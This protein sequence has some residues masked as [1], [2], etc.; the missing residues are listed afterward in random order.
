MHFRQ[1]SDKPFM[2][3]WTISLF[4]CL[5][6]PKTSNYDYIQLIRQMLPQV[7]QNFSSETRKQFLKNTKINV[8][9][10][11]V[12][13]IVVIY[14]I[15]ISSMTHALTNIT[16]KQKLLYSQKYSITKA[17]CTQITLPISLNLNLSRERQTNVSKGHLSLFNKQIKVNQDTFGL[18]V[19]PSRNKTV[20]H[21][22]P[23]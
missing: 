4:Y 18:L 23:C 16:K 5:S 6:K 14:L 10:T 13:D 3:T 1:G 21:Y 22:I 9:S 17:W 2:T 7:K 15:K 8:K 19:S 12:N 11:E 20:V